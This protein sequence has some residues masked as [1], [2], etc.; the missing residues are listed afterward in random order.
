MTPD[1]GITVP[2][3]MLGVRRVQL[4][5]PGAVMAGARN[6]AAGVTDAVRDRIPNREHMLYYGGLGA[7]AAFGVLSW[8]AAAAIGAGVWVAERAFGS[9]RQA[10]M[11]RN[12]A[13]GQQS[14]GQ[15]PGMSGRPALPSGAGAEGPQASANSEPTT[16]RRE[17]L[18]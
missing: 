3:P 4:P 2:V 18:P 8:P 5:A 11:S 13:A 12:Q 9:G 14:P 6:G 7:M 17:P 10:A 16:R 1:G 15:R